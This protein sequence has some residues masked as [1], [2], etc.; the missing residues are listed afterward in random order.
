[1]PLNP[2]MMLQL[3]EKWAID[4]LGPIAPQGKMGAHYIITATK[5]LIQWA[6]AWPVK[7]YTTVTTAKFLF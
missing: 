7:D 2:Q 4:F 6:E 3:F 1:M 5:Y